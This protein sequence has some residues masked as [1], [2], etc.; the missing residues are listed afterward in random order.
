MEQQLTYGILGKAV[1]L[2]AGTTIASILTAPLQT[3]VTSMQ[4]SVVPHKELFASVEARSKELAKLNTELT[5][6]EK[7]RLEL[8]IRSGG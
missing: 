7:R 5:I 3:V 8:M 4:L 1:N 2:V 6:A